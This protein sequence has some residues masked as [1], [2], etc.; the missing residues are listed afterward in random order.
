MPE[1]KATHNNTTITL[2]IPHDTK[3]FLDDLAR[4]GYNRSNLM[5]NNIRTMQVLDETYPGIPLPDGLSYLHD[6]VSSGELAERYKDG[7]RIPERAPVL[8]DK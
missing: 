7:R 8:A 4:R 3:T 1:P 6:I 5:L 2:S